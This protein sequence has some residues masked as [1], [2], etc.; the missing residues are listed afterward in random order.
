VARRELLAKACNEFLNSL[1]AGSIP[2]TEAPATIGADTMPFTPVAPVADDDEQKIAG[3]NEWAIARG[4]PAGAVLFEL[5]E[6]ETGQALGVLDLAWPDGLQ[7]ELSGPVAVVLDDDPALLDA[8]TR[9]GYRVFVEPET[10]RAY[11]E[12][13]ILADETAEAAD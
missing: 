8:A 5:A 12:R 13:E 10:F 9:A 1:F 6:P 11:V 7:P 2:E 3:I 4:L